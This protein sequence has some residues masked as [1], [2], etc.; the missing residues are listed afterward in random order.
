MLCWVGDFSP[1]DVMR[2]GL[3]EGMGVVGVVA[4]HSGRENGKQV[5]GLRIGRVSW[6]GR[7]LLGLPVK[8]AEVVDEGFVGCGL[9]GGRVV[10]LDKISVK[11]G[12]EFLRGHDVGGLVVYGGIVAWGGLDSKGG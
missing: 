8:V 5:V 4:D 11:L 9:S 2:V 10:E 7:L 1:C 12:Q 6:V 3:V